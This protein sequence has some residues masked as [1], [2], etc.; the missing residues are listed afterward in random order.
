MRFLLDAEIQRRGRGGGLPL[1]EGKKVGR[2][3]GDVKMG[4]YSLP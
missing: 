3:K 1:S 2:G 4:A